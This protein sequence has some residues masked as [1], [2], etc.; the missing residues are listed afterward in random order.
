MINT[1]GLVAVLDANVLY[2]VPVRDILLE[3][4]DVK[5]FQPKWTNQIHEEWIRSL[6]KNRHDIDPKVLKK[7][8]AT[9]DKAFPDANV[10][11]YESLIDGITLPDTDDRH[12]LAAAIKS[13][14]KIIVTN[15]LKDFPVKHLKPYHIE[16]LSPDR[17]VKNL[18]ALDENRALK[19]FKA[20]VH[21][22]VNPPLSNAQ[23]LNSLENCGLTGSVAILKSLLK[24]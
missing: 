15:N 6:L 4:A 8:Q 1:T 7:L 13:K 21:R 22:L 16:A 23:I 9:M 12:V 18:I 20:Q 24:I 17:F 14:A 10:S 3:M 5:L 19:A 11:S 2:P